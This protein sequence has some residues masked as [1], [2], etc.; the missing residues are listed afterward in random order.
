MPDAQSRAIAAQSVLATGLT[1]AH[2]L[3]TR[4]LRNTLLFAG[5]G[6]ALP[7][8]GEYSAVNQVRVVRHRTRPQLGGVSL[9]AALGWYNVGYATFAMVESLAPPDLAPGRRRW[10]LPAVTALT[11]TS[12]DLLFDCYG[13]A[14]G[15]WEWH[16]GGP[17]ASEIRGANSRRG[18]P[19]GN[20]GSWLVLTGT[21]T[22]LY[23]SLGHEP[24]TPAGQ[25]GRT[26]GLLFLPYYLRP[27]IW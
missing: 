3:R 6:L 9:N 19:L 1:L 14:E 16:A 27:L 13:L 7:F 25:A 26:A 18:I 17:Y 8:I 15:F 23:L 21:V 22:F 12:L 20:F 11:A 4:G 2:S 5:L 10:L 24:A